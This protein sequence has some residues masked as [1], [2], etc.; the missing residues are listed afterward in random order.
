MSKGSDDTEG[1]MFLTREQ[2]QSMTN[3][4]RPKRI[5]R[6]LRE[7]LPGRFRV[8]VDGWPVVHVKVA[9]DVF[10]VGAKPRQAGKIHFDRVFSPRKRNR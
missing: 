5:I 3:A 2:I 1:Q 9:E 8:G 7:N 4:K 6:W 10:G